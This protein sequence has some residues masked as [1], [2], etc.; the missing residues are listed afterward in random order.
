MTNI[1]IYIINLKHKNERRAKM[2]EQIENLNFEY[3]FVDATYW[4]D[5]DIS[6][7]KLDANFRNVFTNTVMTH[8]EIG[9]A[10]S[11]YN[12]WKLAQTENV[13]YSIILEDDVLIVDEDFEDTIHDIINNIEFDMFYL[14][15]SSNNHEKD[16]KYMTIGKSNIIKP[17]H[18]YWL[19]A[20]ILSKK[21][22]NKL[23][24][25]GFEQNLIT[26][27]DFI[28]YL[29]DNID[30]LNYINPN[31]YNIDILETYALEKNIIEPIKDTFMDSDTDHSP[32][33]CKMNETNELHFFNEQFIVVSVATDRNDCFERFMHSCNIYGIPIHILGLDTTWNGNNM[34]EQEGGGHKI[35]MLK[36]FLSQFSDNDTRVMLFTDSY[37]VVFCNSPHQILKKWEDIHS[38]TN[39]KVLFS[40]ESILWPNIGNENEFP[41]IGSPFKYLNSGG[42]I[43][44]ICDIK[45]MISDDIL[46]SDDDQLYFHNKYTSSK[47]GN[48]IIDYMSYIFQTLSSHHENILVDNYFCNIKNIRYDTSPCV[49]HGNGGIEIKKYFNS[50]CNFLLFNYRIY[51]GSKHQLLEQDVS[52]KK[53]LCIYFLTKKNDIDVIESILSQTVNKNVFVFHDTKHNLRHPDI[54]FFKTKHFDVI[55]SE[56]LSNF[57]YVY[58]GSTNNVITNNDMLKILIK[59]NKKFVSPYIN[60]S[61][62]YFHDTD[63]KNEITRHSKKGLWAIDETNSGILVNSEA[64]QCLLNNIDTNV[65]IFKQIC[66][67]IHMSYNLLYLDNRFIFGY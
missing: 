24:N 30:T 48:I 63:L 14:S 26:V 22:L 52:T 40:A 13:D 6:Q 1:K 49:I 36:T 5:L 34:L 31:L 65:C 62:F 21:G 38:V 39:C 3:S 25:S 46:D 55:M 9:C 45:K 18:S 58:F 23:S 8:G 51:Y 43:G 20:Y 11:H 66:S 47:D 59:T 61:N 7:C 2:V 15:K 33:Y 28:P 35:N 67:N 4:K 19:C 57:H 42:Y 10:I 54:L 53:V 17:G 60:Y 37:D 29:Y 41:D 27:D 16:S 64:C 44:K 12:T 50:L 56:S 32:Y